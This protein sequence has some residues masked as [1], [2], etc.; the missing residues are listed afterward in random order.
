VACV[1]TGVS[2]LDITSERSGAASERCK[3]L[4]AMQ[5]VTWFCDPCEFMGKHV[6]LTG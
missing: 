2:Y 5:I 6:W 1:G 3:F 4:T